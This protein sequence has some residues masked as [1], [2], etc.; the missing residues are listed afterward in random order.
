MKE[1][2]FVLVNVYAPTKDKYVKQ[3]DFLKDLHELIENYSE[4]N[5]LIGGD[6]NV[7]LN[8]K[9]DKRGGV[10][11]SQSDYSKNLQGLITEFN[12]V[13]IWRLRNQDKFQFTRREK[14]KSGIVQSRLD[15]WIVSSALEYSIE[16]VDIKPG[17]CSDHSILNVRIELIGTQT[18]GKSTWKFNNNL[19][20]DDKYLALVKNT[21]AFQR[22]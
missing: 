5:L 8:P 14:T 2:I 1:I 12:L 19:L 21:T 4:K 3:N 17:Y 22:M 7:Y 18:R 16:R 10:A 6:F 11:E 15:Y 20:H 9:C 13:D